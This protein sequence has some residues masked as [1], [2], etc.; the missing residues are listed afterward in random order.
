MRVL[1]IDPGFDR[2][3][4]SIIERGAKKEQLIYSECFKTSPK[5]AFSKRLL[6]ISQEI[7]RVIEE[8]SPAALAIETLL[9]N[10]N[11]KTAMHVAEA[12][13]V[14]ICGAEKAGM[15][16]FEYTP[17][18]IK[19]ALTG[20]GKAEKYQVADM[21]R[22]ILGEDLKERIDDEMDAIAIAMTCLASEK[23]LK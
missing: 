1:G 2:V 10:T 16:I 18:Q 14:I 11:Q 9:F 22:R 21:V 15:Y 19:I 8:F 17:S 12:R 6:L 20:Y 5:L 23:A 4:I 7:D 3:G 13:G